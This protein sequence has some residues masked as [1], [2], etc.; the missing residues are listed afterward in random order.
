MAS[1]RIAINVSVGQVAAGLQS[2]LNILSENRRDIAQLRDIAEQ[3]AAGEDWTSFGALFGVDAAQAET[4]YNNLVNLDN[5]LNNDASS[6]FLTLL[7]AQT[8]TR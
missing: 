3:A 8:A 4:M 6:D 2:A 1:T 5:Y 7:L